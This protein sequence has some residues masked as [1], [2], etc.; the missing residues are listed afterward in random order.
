MYT[1]FTFHFYYFT[2]A[3]N[4]YCSESIHYENFKWGFPGGS[5]NKESAHNAGDPGSI[6]GLGRSPGEGNVCPLQYRLE[7]SMD[8]GAWWATAHGVAKS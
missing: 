8:R 5:H 6:L 1:T 3:G 2:E 7:D 4:V